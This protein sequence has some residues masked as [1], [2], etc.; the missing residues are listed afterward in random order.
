M[1]G[2]SSEFP[3]DSS[4]DIFHHVEIC[5]EED[6]EEALMDLDEFSRLYVG[7]KMG[8]RA[9]KGCGNWHVS[10]TI[11]SLHHRCII[12]G[13]RIRETAKVACYEPVGREICMKNVEELHQS[14]GNVFRFGKVWSER[15]S[16]PQAPE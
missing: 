2:D 8:E 9:Y 1:T 4:V 15:K 14:S 7:K 3:C 11:P 6:I 12:S 5:R 16:G 10:S 13:N